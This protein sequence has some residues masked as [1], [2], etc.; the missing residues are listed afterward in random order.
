MLTADG[1]VR[2]RSDAR[3]PRDVRI[4]D[5]SDSEM[6]FFGRLT[7]KLASADWEPTPVGC[8]IPFVNVAFTLLPASPV[9]GGVN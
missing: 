2:F 5:V 7:V 6:R 4:V 9:M 1:S 8:P 3:L